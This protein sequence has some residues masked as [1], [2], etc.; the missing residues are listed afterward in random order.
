MSVQSLLDQAASLRREARHVWFLHNG[1]TPLHA[2]L[3]GAALAL[4]RAASHLAASN[5]QVVY[6]RK[7]A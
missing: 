5:N 6:R 2:S 7:Q 4:E 3:I 1:E